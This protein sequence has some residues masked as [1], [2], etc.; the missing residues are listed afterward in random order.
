MAWSSRDRPCATYH[1]V[2]TARRTRRPSRAP[3]RGPPARGFIGGSRSPRTERRTSRPST[4]TTAATTRSPP[5]ATKDCGGAGRP[6][7]QQVEQEPADSGQAAVTT[8]RTLGRASRGLP[9]GRRRDGAG[10][11]RRRQAGEQV[12]HPGRGRRGPSAARAA[13]PGG[14]ALPTARARRRGCAARGCGSS[15]VG[16]V[17]HEVAV[18]DRR[19]R[20]GCGRP[21]G[22]R[23]SRP[24]RAST[25]RQAASSACGRE[26]AADHDHG[27][28]VVRLLGAAHRLGLDHGRDGHDLEAGVPR[29][30]RPPPRPASRARSPRLAPRARTPSRGGGNSSARVRRT[31]D[32]DVAERLARSAPAACARR[33]RRPRPA[34]S[35]RQVRAAAR[36][37]S[38]AGR[39]ARRGRRRRARGPA[40]RSA[41][42]GRG[43]RWRPRRAV[44]LE[45]RRRRRSPARRAARGSS[46][47]CCPR[48]T[49]PLQHDPVAGSERGSSGSRRR[50][51][52]RRRAAATAATPDGVRGARASCTRTPTRRRPRPA[53]TSRPWRRRGPPSGAAVPVAE[54]AATAEP[55]NRLRDVPTS[56]GRPSATSCVEAR[57]QRPVVLGAS[58]RI[59]DPGPARRAPRRPRPRPAPRPAAAELV[60]HVGH[61]VVVDG[62]LLHPVAV[63]APVHGDVGHPGVGD[64]PRPCAGSARPPL[65]SL[66]SA[67]PASSAARPP[68]PASCRC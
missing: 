60:A 7:D 23:R 51:R 29:E 11:R 31:V 56:S 14:R 42:S 62:E 17:E 15:E 55:R 57:E 20:P 43:R 21:S 63:P 67:A 48:A 41:R 28:E 35:A 12:G 59:P 5:P 4:S 18:G 40:R 65:T 19:R 39:R 44:E 34:E 24:C 50:R 27:V 16:A 36:P 61:D 38:P 32:G 8:A 49:R 2:R 6:A 1:P 53:P 66:T 33:P 68:R 64:Q 30:L 9:P 13:A 10:R 58:S 26:R 54:G 25:A 22:P 37:G 47:P 46:T 45:Q 52:R 3:R